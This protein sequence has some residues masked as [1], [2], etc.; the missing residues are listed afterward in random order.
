MVGPRGLSRPDG[1]K[2]RLRGLQA[3]TGGHQNSRRGTG[4]QDHPPNVSLHHAARISAPATN[5][6]IYVTSGRLY[7]PSRQSTRMEMGLPNKATDDMA[8]GVPIDSM[9]GSDIPPPAR[10]G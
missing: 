9:P 8:Q 6:P 7:P 4:S 1:T 2:C 3:P 10:A 5:T